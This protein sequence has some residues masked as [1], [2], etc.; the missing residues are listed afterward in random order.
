MGTSRRCELVSRGAG[1]GYGAEVGTG[2]Q[3]QQRNAS[4]G[5][6]GLVQ[7]SQQGKE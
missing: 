3:I 1:R 2:L 5:L 7:S 4:L 6:A